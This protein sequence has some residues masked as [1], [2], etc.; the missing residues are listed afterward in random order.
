MAT[1]VTTSR[2]ALSAVPAAVAYYIVEYRT[3][4]PWV[5]LSGHVT[6]GTQFRWTTA[7][8]GATYH[9]RVRGYASDHVAS[10]PSDVITHYTG[11]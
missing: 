8:R 6:H 5:P 11:G 7:S 10:E 3:V 2:V 9:F 1:S 4:G